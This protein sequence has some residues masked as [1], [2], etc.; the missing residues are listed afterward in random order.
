MC[1]RATRR[2]PC[3]RCP[4][5]D[6]ASP[7]V[8]PAE[9]ARVHRPETRGDDAEPERRGR[10]EPEQLETTLHPCRAE[11]AEPVDHG[12]DEILGLVAVFL[13]DDRETDFAA[14]PRDGVL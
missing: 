3:R 10:A 12:V 13:V 14:R 9:A 11:I 8:L 7:F 2:W 1:R 6:R 5:T 4:L